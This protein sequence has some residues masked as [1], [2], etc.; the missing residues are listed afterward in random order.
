[1]SVVNQVG[2]R[3]VSGGRI[4]N[5]VRESIDLQFWQIRSHSRPK[6]A[7]QALQDEGLTVSGRRDLPATPF[8]LPYDWSANP[9]SDRN[10][11]FQL[12]GWRMLDPFFN[13]MS[14]DDVVF[15]GRVMTDWQQFE[16][17][18]PK[19]TPW[20]WYDMSTGL[21]A[22]KLGALL[23]WC[24]EHGVS[25]P[26]SDAVFQSLVDAH[27]AHLTNPKELSQGNH[28]LTQL[29]GLMALLHALERTGRKVSQQADAEKFALVHMGQLLQRQLGAYGVHTEDAPDYHFYALG[30]IRMILAAL[31]W[32]RD[33][34]AD[35][36]VTLDGAEIAKEWLV[37]PALRCPPVGD[38]G[39]SVKLKRL[40]RLLEW[41]HA[42]QGSSIAAQLDGYGVVRTL[43]EL[44]LDQSHYLLFQGSF[45]S[46]AHKH[47]DC[48][49]FVW[50]EGGRYLLW[51]SGKYGYQTDDWR[52]YFLSNRAHNTVEVDSLDF[53]R[54]KSE[55]Y[56][57][58]IERVAACQ[59]GWLLA[60]KVNHPRQ[61]IVH[62]RV[63]FYRPGVGIDVL[64]VV[65]NTVRR[66]G[67]LGLWRKNRRQF[68]WWWQLGHQGRLRAMSAG[69]AAFIH[70]DGEGV[71]VDVTSSLSALPDVRHHIG[72]RH[73]R[74]AGWFSRGYLKKQP[75]NALSFEFQTDRSLFAVASRWR[76]AKH[77][78]VAPVFQFDGEELAV[79]GQELHD[80][81]AGLLDP[82]VK[83]V[84]RQ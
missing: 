7:I 74:I 60:G 80:A 64:D 48:L 83:L 17:T 23:V 61:K 82:E 52:D 77:A 63:L 44:P 1:M 41:P 6:V 47:S 14:R 66:H 24:Q 37:T 19:A 76:V 54:R 57:T 34:L 79:V 12:H 25:L 10:W 13:R 70:D 36:R 84:R 33:E 9:H 38:S 67:L 21:R 2:T 45:Y 5:I 27:I 42:V 28:G 69:C 81:V 55:G 58:A 11:M 56:G 39:E 78:D 16:S 26:M 40:T 30:Q 18:N 4:S 75:S 22:C 29:N 62:Q 46:N 71:T 59:D 68:R 3:S 20:F 31:W 15:I 43:P 72:E 73:P 49:S 51:D 32:Q 8:K 50:Q 65:R 53:T 35:I